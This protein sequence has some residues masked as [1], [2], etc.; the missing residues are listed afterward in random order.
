[1]FAGCHSKTNH[2]KLPVRK[3]L[4]LQ[5]QASRLKILAFLCLFDGHDKSK[6]HLFKW[7]LKAFEDKLQVR[8]DDRN[9]GN[10]NCIS[11]GT[12]GKSDDF[13][14]VFLQSLLYMSL[15]PLQSR[16]NSNYH[17]SIYLTKFRSSIK[18]SLTGGTRG[19]SR[20]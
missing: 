5:V 10:E 12:S 9:L 11:F 8:L 14:H 7:K 20:D 16:D 4:I 2:V 13:D 17:I 6:S 18:S 19:S 1:M 15:V 3:T